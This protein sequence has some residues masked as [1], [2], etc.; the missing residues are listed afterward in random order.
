MK[1]IISNLELVLEE[2]QQEAWSKG[3]EKGKSE[4]KLEVARNLLLLLAEKR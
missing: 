2:M 4:G 3:L 1:K